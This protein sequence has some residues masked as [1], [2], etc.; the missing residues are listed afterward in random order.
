LLDKTHAQN[1]R[2]EQRN[3]ELA[4]RDELITRQNEELQAQTEE[5]AQQN[6]ELQNQSEEMALQNQEL[7]QQGEELQA[8]TEELQ[9]IINELNER[10][11]MLHTLLSSI[12]SGQHESKVPETVCETLIKLMRGAAA[13][14]AIVEKRES[15]AVLHT[16]AGGANL[17]R[18]RWRWKGSFSE[19]VVRG[20]TTAY[21]DD[22]ASQTL[23][24]LP[25]GEAGFHSVLVTPLRVRDRLIGTLEVYSPIPRK[26][27]TDEFRI[28]EW[29]AGQ[30]S[31]AID[32]IDLQEKLRHSEEQFRVMAN[33]L[34]QLAWIAYGNGDVL[35]FNRRWYDYTGTSLEQMTGW[36]WQSVHDPAVL[37]SVLQR[38]QASL[39][40]G[41]DFDMEF[42][43][44]GA[45]G[46]FRWFL[47]RVTPIRDYAGTVV[48]WIGTH[49][50][51]TEKRDAEQALKA[52]Q[53]FLA[54]TNQHLERLV[55]ERTAK[56][57]ELVD[58]LE[59]F[60]Y[61][62]THDMRAPLRAMQGF[63]SMLE[64][65]LHVEGDAKDYLDNIK[66][67]AVR[68]D[69]LITDALSYSKAL[70]QELVVEPVNAEELLLSIVNS[71]PALQQPHAEISISGPIPLVLG[72]EAALTQC[73]SNFLG[74]A[75][76][77]VQTNRTP[78]VRIWAE[79][80]EGMVRIWFEDNGIGIPPHAIS[81]LFQM[82]Q[83]A[84]KSYEGTGVGLALVRKVAER[85]GGK[86]GVESEPGNGSRFWLE[87]RPAAGECHGDSDY[88]K[89]FGSPDCAVGF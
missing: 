28:L 67:S 18:Q 84:N 43:L 52:A 59:H 48:R 68:M 72:N 45:D 54:D 13:A 6:E 10:E 86:V 19:L 60:S 30:C 21:I 36:G 65:T 46:K 39:S 3:A 85:M 88:D 23:A 80:R 22:L 41:K 20:G 61:T 83:R 74:N 58:E 49:T 1:Q 56:L 27:T 71:Y 79:P 26:W 82:F 44:R 12:R 8:Q 42:P 69:R 76:K 37:P 78:Q 33:A 47:T 57:Q 62:I 2:L 9:V 29:T 5:L 35:W 70:K 55:K 81:R 25:Y 73:F 77:F 24:E 16:T 31:M 32:I 7:D 11:A 87:L 34:P 53:Q 63:A 89:G 17:L 66:R 40:S 50:D 14:A 64:E 75:V 38:W 15:D 51:I 4:A